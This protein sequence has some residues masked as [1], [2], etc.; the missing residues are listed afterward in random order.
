MR[1]LK[2]MPLQKLGNLGLARDLD[3][4][5]LPIPGEVQLDKLPETRRA[6]L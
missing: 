1:I 4:P 5:G 6:V 2:A 3:G